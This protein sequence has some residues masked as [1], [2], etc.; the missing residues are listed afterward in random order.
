[1]KQLEALYAELKSDE[2]Y[3]AT[4]TLAYG[5]TNP[6]DVALAR[7]DDCGALPEKKIVGAHKTRL[8][9]QC[10][11]CKKASKNVQKREWQAAIEWNM[12]NL[13]SLSIQDIPLFEVSGMAPKEITKRVSGIRRNLEIRNK[14]AKIELELSKKT[15]RRAPGSQYM[16]KLDVYLRWA[17]LALRVAKYQAKQQSVSGEKS[18]LRISARNLE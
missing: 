2:H 14:I 12:I 18:A 4:D 17:M 5:H 15:N 3:Q 9:Y 16:L 10:A 7:C 8:V 1:M 6:F 11:G 13:K